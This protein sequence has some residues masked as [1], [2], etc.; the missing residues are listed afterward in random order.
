MFSHHI[1]GIGWDST[2]CI[3]RSSDW[4]C[5]S[6]NS[7]RFNNYNIL[8]HSGIWRAADEAVLNKKVHEIQAKY[9]EEEDIFQIYLIYSQGLTWL[10]TA[11]ST[12]ITGTWKAL[13]AALAVSRDLGSPIPMRPAQ[14]NRV[15]IWKIMWICST[16]FRPKFGT[17]W[18]IVPQ[19]RLNKKNCWFRHCSILR[20][21]RQSSY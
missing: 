1:W 2:E 11:G 6:R 21:Y 5:L 4:Q 3:V 7:P 15:N 16:N 13:R 12:A 17:S 8:R 10:K 19:R 20:S 14:L 18:K 9:G